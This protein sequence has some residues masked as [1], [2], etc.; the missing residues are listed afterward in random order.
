MLADAYPYTAYSAGLLSFL[1][2]WAG[3]GGWDAA[4]GRLSDPAKRSRIRDEM[5]E[6]VIDGLG[7]WSLVVIASVR[8]EASRELIGKNL[9][10]IA[11]QWSVEPGRPPFACSRS[12]MA[13][14][15]SSATR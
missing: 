7:R 8:K 14:C 1:P 12:R 6:S 4:V 3:E 2:A 9:E 5:D 10:E 11:D 15:A 13:R